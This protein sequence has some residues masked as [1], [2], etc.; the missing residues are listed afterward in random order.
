M[1]PFERFLWEWRERQER[2]L[3]GG[4]NRTESAYEASAGAAASPASP[5]AQRCASGQMRPMPGLSLWTRA[6][7]RAHMAWKRRR[8]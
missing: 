2:L 1:S 7:H 8:R 5:A 4:G 3:A 6:H